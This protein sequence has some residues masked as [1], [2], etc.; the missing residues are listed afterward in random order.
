MGAAG[1]G[2]F[3]TE[4]LFMGHQ[5]A[6]TEAEQVDA[7][8]R[9]FEA[10][11]PGPPVLVRLADIGGDKDIP[12]LA[13]PGEANPFLGVRAL[14][15]AYRD[16]GLLVRQIRAISAA[17]ALA[18]VVPH[19]MAPMVATIDDV[20]LLHDLIAEA[21]SDLAASGS[22]RSQR[23]V[24]GIMV[25]IPAAALSAGE[26]APHV[27]FFSIGTND[28]T[29]YLMAA[30]RTNPA[31]VRLHDAL[32][33]A[34]LRC[35]AMVVDGA[36]RI[37][38]PVA[39]CGELAGDPVG[40]LV[41]VGLGVD[42]LSADAGSLDALRFQLAGVTRADLDQLAHLALGA[43]D[44]AEVRAWRALC[45]VGLRSCWRRRPPDGQ[46]PG[47]GS[48][49]GPAARAA[50]L[51]R[52]SAPV[53]AGRAPPHPG[54]SPAPD[55]RRAHRRVRARRPR[56]RHRPARDPRWTPPIPRHPLRGEPMAAAR[57]GP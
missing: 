34:V 38:I 5:T 11:G 35:I 12:Y 22:A 27:D 36:D 42:E 40:A 21:Q 17:A 49:V 14:R 15:L 8:R 10:F 1:V 4:F 28:L 54:S 53:L 19:V 6:P 55:A 56:R 50:P 30:D 48:G 39:V 57:R 26:L 7:Y 2:L 41:L 25:E 37:G 52:S 9:V 47:I 16:R 3:R 31:L 20:D 46:V 32:H 29:Q 18:G 44:G 13:L 51:R 45:S 24:T 23:I 43:R 33:P